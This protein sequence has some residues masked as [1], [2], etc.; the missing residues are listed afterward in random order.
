VDVW[1][2]VVS[3]PGSSALTAWTPGEPMTTPDVC[4]CGAGVATTTSGGAMN[5]PSVFLFQVLLDSY[6]CMVST[7]L[8]SA[9]FCAASCASWSFACWATSWAGPLKPNAAAPAALAMSQ[10]D[11]AGVVTGTGG[12]ML[13]RASETNCPWSSDEILIT[14]APV[15]ASLAHSASGVRPAVALS[16]ALPSQREP[17]WESLALRSSSSSV[18][19]FA[20]SCQ[21]VVCGSDAAAPGPALIIL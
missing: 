20:R 11:G 13:E 8:S 6:V 2:V 7:A 17:S 10:P 3:A 21:Y 4:P 15:W 19:S 1:V 18:S 9:S 16:A 12:G 14:V 5:E